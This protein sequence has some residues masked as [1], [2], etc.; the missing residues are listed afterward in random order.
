MQDILLHFLTYLQ[1]KVTLDLTV[2]VGQF[3]GLSG[4]T[5]TSSGSHL[6]YEVSENGKTVNPLDYYRKP[7]N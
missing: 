2:S 6:H 1:I 3:I 7:T 4:N 5:G